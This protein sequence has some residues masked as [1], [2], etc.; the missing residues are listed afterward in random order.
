M[1]S[2]EKFKN[3]TFDIN[4]VTPE[5]PEETYDIILS[6]LMNKEDD[7]VSGALAVNK[8]KMNILVDWLAKKYNDCDVD[9]LINKFNYTELLYNMVTDIVEPAKFEM[10][11]SFHSELVFCVEKNDDYFCGIRANHFSV[12]IGW[13]ETTP[14]T[15]VIVT[16]NHKGLRLSTMYKLE[17]S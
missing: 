17:N 9:Y 16:G 1:S 5:E 7:F 14:G 12:E 11:T 13:T 8:D 3:V 6:R 2:F 4:S 10:Y 15:F